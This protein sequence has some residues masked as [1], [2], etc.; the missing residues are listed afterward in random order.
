MHKIFSTPFADVYRLY[1][2]KVERKG[3]T[4]VELNVVISWL[5]GYD[6]TELSKQLADRSTFREFFGAA[7]MNPKAELIT[8]KICG[9]QIE[10]IAD[11]LMKQIRYLDKLVDEVANGRK[12]EKILRT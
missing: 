12:L 11:P 10:E 3:H 9:V 2:A 1:L 5:T 4:Q 6:E 8:G 7:R